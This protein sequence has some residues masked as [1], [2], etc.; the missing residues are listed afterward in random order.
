MWVHVR[1]D[2]R[3]DSSVAGEEIVS[4]PYRYARPVADGTG[5]DVGAEL[6]E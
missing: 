3:E 6:E 1:A 5:A 2:Y 4:K